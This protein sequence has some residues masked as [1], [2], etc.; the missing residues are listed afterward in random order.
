MVY[1]I[2]VILWMINKKLL[3]IISWYTYFRWG[4]SFFA[5]NSVIISKITN[6]FLIKN[7]IC[8]VHV[9]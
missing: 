4:V 2:P 7:I 3:N 9:N 1:I 8:N 5:E 6:V